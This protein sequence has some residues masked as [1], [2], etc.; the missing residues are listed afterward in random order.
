MVEINK[1]GKALLHQLEVGRAAG[2][3]WGSAAARWLLPDAAC[4]S[5]PVALSYTKSVLSLTFTL[6]HCLTAKLCECR[7]SLIVHI[8]WSNSYYCI[9]K[10][11]QNFPEKYAHLVMVLLLCIATLMKETFYWGW[12]TVSQFR[13]IFIMAKKRASQ[14][15]N[16]QDAGEGTESSTGRICATPVRLELPRPQSRPPVTQ[17]PPRSHLTSW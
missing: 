1:K 14:C 9:I 5:P 12:R 3:V 6:Q 16:R 17:F 8:H 10:G 15:A 4:G 11:I 13:S 2:R 7:V